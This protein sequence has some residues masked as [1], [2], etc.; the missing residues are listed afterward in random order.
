MMNT[1]YTYLATK[2]KVYAFNL[3]LHFAPY[4]GSEIFV[5][6]HQSLVLLVDIEDFTDP[7]SS[8]RSLLR[9]GEGVVVGRNVRHDG[10]LVRSHRAGDI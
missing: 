5:L 2:L 8:L 3:N 4:P 10:S 6:F 9:A 7:V 1:R